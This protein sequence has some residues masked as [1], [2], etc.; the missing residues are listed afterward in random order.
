MDTGQLLVLSATST[1]GRSFPSLFALLPDKTKPVLVQFWRLVKNFVGDYKPVSLL[2]DLEVA[3]TRSFI[4]VFGDVKVT[5]CL[6]DKSGIEESVLSNLCHMISAMP[7]VPSQ[8]T[9][10]VF[11]T[12]FR[13]CTDQQ[14]K[15]TLRFLDYIQDNFIGRTGGYKGHIPVHLWSQFEAVFGDEDTCQSI[16]LQ[17]LKNALNME[18]SQEELVWTTIGQFGLE[19]EL[20]ARGWSE[21]LLEV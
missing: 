10:H 12:V 2:T 13:S 9:A 4:E 14:S 8:Q 16:L 1:N 11:E 21:A 19:E 17:G 15:E 20:Q 7:F 3:A 5:I 18:S 6:A